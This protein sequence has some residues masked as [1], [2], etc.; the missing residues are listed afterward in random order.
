MS[1]RKQRTLRCLGLASGKQVK[2]GNCRPGRASRESFL[3]ARPTGA[4]PNLQHIS[5]RE[6][7]DG[8]GSVSVGVPAGFDSWPDHLCASSNE[9]KGGLAG[10]PGSRA[11]SVIVNLNGLPAELLS[12][13]IPPHWVDGIA[14]LESHQVPKDVPAHRWRQFINDCHTFLLAKENWAERAAGHGWND[15]ELFGCCR[16]P[17]ERLGNAES[18]NLSSA[19]AM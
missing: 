6:Q 15:L 13:R 5:R 9:I 2:I 10:S 16:R 17:L 3:P 11:R 7:A 1:A 12:G 19:G 18:V 4:A 14:R 8:T